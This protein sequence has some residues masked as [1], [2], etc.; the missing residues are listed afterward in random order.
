MSV[1]EIVF[2][3]VVNSSLTSPP[4]TNYRRSR[5]E[6]EPLLSNPRGSPI[7]PSE[8]NFDPAKFVGNNQWMAT[9][10][11]LVHAV[12]VVA[13][14]CPN[15]RSPL[16]SQSTHCRSFLRNRLCDKSN[17]HPQ[18][19]PPPLSSLTFTTVARPICSRLLHSHILPARA[20]PN[21]QPHLP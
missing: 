17:P 7:A 10:S 11:F 12:I 8:S 20:T 9:V 1:S 14:L 16:Q 19:N 21:R 18:F 15:S 2:R 3:D 4:S 6:P 5:A 13:V